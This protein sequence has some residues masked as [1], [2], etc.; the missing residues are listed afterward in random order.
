MSTSLTLPVPIP[1]EE[2]NLN[3]YFHTSFFVSKG[4]MKALNARDGKG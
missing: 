3:F 4:F 1:N 2:Y